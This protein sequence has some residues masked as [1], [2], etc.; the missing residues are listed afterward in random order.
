MNKLT[1]V[2]CSAL[3]GSLAA[4]S[5]ANAGDLTVTGGADMTWTSLS[6]QVTGNPLG[7]G[8]NFVLKGDGEL[9][10]GWT[11][12]LAI[13]H[14]N[15]GVYSTTTIDLGLGSLGS[16][17]FNQG[18]SGNGIDSFD[19]KMP[20]A[21]EE[22]WGA[23]LSTGVK[24]VS[25]VG[26]SQNIQYTLP[27][28]LGS[29]LKVAY[30]PS[31]GSTDVN[32]KAVGGVSHTAAT[33]RGVDITLN[34]NPS[35]GTEVLSGLNLFGG[36]SEIEQYDPSIADN[37][38]EGTVGYTYSLGPV[39]IGGQ[40]SAQYTGETDGQQTNV[41]KTTAF[42]VAFNINDN[43]SASY[44]TMES[45][46]AGHTHSSMYTNGDLIT[47]KSVQ[48]AYTMGGASVRLA[49]VTADNTYFSTA[50]GADVQAMIVS[51]G[52]AF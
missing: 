4:I 7:V 22:A 31:V 25:G 18:N 51:L 41:Y 12:A 40:T 1:K 42:G 38:Y 37:K 17:N 33:G 30:A 21:W 50:A 28:V 52:L 29:T 2:G 44:G 14:D 46:K 45:R 48:A 24:L 49:H 43:L 13:N 8:S 10:N 27:T 35:F 16:I 32:D 15:K 6:D 5:A 36:A 9:D 47:V 39:S 20:T 11:V 34:I 23:G 26:P 3:C 19:D